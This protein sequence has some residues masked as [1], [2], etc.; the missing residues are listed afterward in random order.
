M[1]EDGA[2]VCLK[3]FDE[4]IGNTDTIGLSVVNNVGLLVT[5]RLVEVVGT[6]A[7][8]VVVGGGNTEI[9]DFSRWAQGRDQVITASAAGIRCILCQTG[10]GVS[11]ANLSE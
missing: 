10:V 2:A 1:T 8:L 3:L 11:R 4:G 7:T 9:R 5:L 6:H